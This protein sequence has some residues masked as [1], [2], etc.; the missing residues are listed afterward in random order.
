MLIWT[1][2]SFLWIT[3]PFW[4]YKYATSKTSPIELTWLYCAKMVGYLFF[5]NATNLNFFINF[6]LLNKMEDN[7]A[8]F[9]FQRDLRNNR[10]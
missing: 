9:N 1:P 4:V 10:I 6:L 8:W 2:C 3:V 5:E 7:I